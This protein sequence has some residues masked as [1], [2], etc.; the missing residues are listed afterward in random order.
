MNG[1]HQVICAQG[2]ARWKWSLK[3][4]NVY[5]TRGGARRY[6]FRDGVKTPYMRP[7]EK[8]WRRGK[9]PAYT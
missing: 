6:H 3:M 4:P 7:G 8:G 2:R 1:S 5:N 9:A